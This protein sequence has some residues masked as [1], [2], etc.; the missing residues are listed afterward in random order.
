MIGAEEGGAWQDGDGEQPAEWGQQGGNWT[1]NAPF[2][3]DRFQPTL[4]TYL[5][6]PWCSS[7]SLF[8]FSF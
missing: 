8:L 7:D 3:L 4:K 1:L 6:A 5:R 2:M